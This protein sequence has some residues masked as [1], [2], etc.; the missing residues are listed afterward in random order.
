M[1]P[2]SGGISGQAR[3]GASLE[4]AE[5]ISA[6]DLVTRRDEASEDFVSGTRYLEVARSAVWRW[7]S[8]AWRGVLGGDTN[9]VEALR[10][11]AF[12][13]DQRLAEAASDDALD[14][15]MVLGVEA[16][17]AALATYARQLDGLL[18]RG[19]TAIRR[20][21]AIRLGVDLASW[22]AP[23][24]GQIAHWEGMTTARRGTWPSDFGSA[25]GRV[26][27]VWMGVVTVALLGGGMLGMAWS[28]SGR[29][30][31]PVPG[32][33]GDAGILVAGLAHEIRNPMTVLKGDLT[34]C[35]RTGSQDPGDL[36]RWLGEVRRMERVLDDFLAYARPAAPR[37]E[38]LEARAVMSGVADLV[39]RPMADRR[40]EV[41][42]GEGGRPVW[43][44]ADPGQLRQV[45]LNL[46]RNAADSM[47][48][49]GRIT[50]GVTT[51]RRAGRG[52]RKGDEVRLE[53]GDQGPGIPED[54]T[55]HLFEPFSSTKPGGSGLGLAIA[56]RLALAQGGDLEYRAGPR[57]GT[58]FSVVLPRVEADRD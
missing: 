30:R 44:R 12:E 13:V 31:G 11:E 23:V 41:V 58:V 16:I 22:S 6:A 1:G 54:V 43:V 10:R 8:L 35:R 27:W 5:A 15:E 46:V 28:R 56:S 33:S 19:R 29:R 3:R 18:G 48:E 14:G 55:G 42:L 26:P 32:V 53:V 52:A 4:A 2:G 20:E 47:P 38:R 7:E 51:G 37:S 34:G 50:L 40:I 21:T 17:R 25:G 45:L 39:R 57:G 36:D 49:G 9:A 24:L